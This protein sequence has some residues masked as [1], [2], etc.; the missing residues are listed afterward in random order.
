MPASRNLHTGNARAGV[1]A[2][3]RPVRLGRLTQS[4]GTWDAVSLYLARCQVSTPDDLVIATWR[5]VLAAR[6]SV[7]KVVDFGAGDGRF[8]NHGEYGEYVGYEIDSRV[9]KDS[10]LPGNARLVNRCA[11]SDTIEDADVCIGNP[12]FVRNQDLPNGWRQRA[13]KVLQDR[14]GVSISGLANAWQYFFFLALASAREDGLV[15]L[16]IP[17]EWVSRPSSKAVRD[18]IRTQGWSVTVYRLVDARFN[19]V[20]TTASITIVDKSTHDGVWSYF[21][22][23][24]SGAYLPMPTASGSAAGVIPYRSRSASPKSLPHARRGLSPGTQKVLTLTEGERVRSGL[25][26]GRD[27]VACVTSLRPVPPGVRSLD[28][29]AMKAYYRLPNRKCWLPRTDIAP[30]PRLAAYLQAVP[31]TDYQTATCLE[32]DEWWKFL[33]PASPEVLISMSFKGSFPKAVRNHAGVRAV[34]GVYGIYGL[35]GSQADAVTLGLGGLDLR[36]SVVAHSNGLRK[37][38]IGQLNTL[39][40]QAFGTR[41]VDE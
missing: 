37:L 1:P 21:A 22:E 27:V 32:R 6:K 25:R 19:S 4:W 14:L 17:Y 5:H 39:L 24:A 12:P 28:E 36:D 10:T 26:I 40:A 34:G 38:E 7:A 20:L 16:I 35:S 41:R 29:E 33:M 9:C 31:A 2:A 8:A 23:T 3:E 13:S 30:S 18:Y 15:A 11:F